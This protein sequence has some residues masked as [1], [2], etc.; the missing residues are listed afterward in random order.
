MPSLSRSNEK[1]IKEQ[2]IQ[3]LY[4]NHPNSYTAKRIGRE[5]IRDNEFVD[6]LLRELEETKIVTVNQN[7]SRSFK[8]YRLTD[9]AKRAYDSK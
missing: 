5:L 1:R 9:I 7:K 2:I 8:Y 6:R 3:F 4:E